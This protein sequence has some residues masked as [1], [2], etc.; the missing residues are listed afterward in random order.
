[1]KKY[2]Y[3]FRLWLSFWEPNMPLQKY[4]ELE[5][6]AGYKGEKGQPLVC[7]KCGCKDFKIGDSYKEEGIG[8]VEYEE[9]CQ[10][11]GNR[12]GYWSYGNWQI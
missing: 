5:I 10:K 8:L 3:R 1:M 9:L 6:K 11:C 4:Q 12:V 7:Y 2:Y